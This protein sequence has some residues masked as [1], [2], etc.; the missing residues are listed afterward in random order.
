MDST[1]ENNQ[2]TPAGIE[3]DWSADIGLDSNDVLFDD[4]GLSGPKIRYGYRTGGMKFLVPE[5]LVSEVLDQTR[6]FYLPN[7]PHWVCGLINMHGKVI[8]VVDLAGLKNNEISHLSK[9]N[10]LAIIQ[11]DTAAGILI[12]GFPEA[13]SESD[14]MTAGDV[15]G[16]PAEFNN[17]IH[18]G[19]GSNGIVWHE[20]DIF[21]LLKD[22]VAQHTDSVHS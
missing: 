11:K 13:V 3:T 19:F 12:D 21:S 2:S 1:T 8:P 16:I 7:A 15:N 22:L 5:G 9:S 17:Y 20:L 6:V 4:N 18:E 14:G 10:I